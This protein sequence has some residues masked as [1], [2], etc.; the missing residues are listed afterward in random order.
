MSFFRG[1]MKMT[2]LHLAM[3]P[4]QLKGPRNAVKIMVLIGQG[5]GCLTAIGNG[6]RKGN[7]DRTLRGDPDLMPQT[8][9]RVEH[10]PRCSRQAYSGVQG[11]G[12]RRRTAAAQ[13]AGPVC[14]VLHRSD[15][16]SI[17]GND[18]DGPDRLL[19]SSTR[20]AAAQKH[21]L[22]RDKLRL[23]KKFPQ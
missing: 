3:C 22:R 1:Q 21:L 20:P 6:R 23:E 11:G 19:V 5:E 17:Q 7:A 9:D 13:E 8:Q 18:M 10:G 4:G 2:E 16:P 15:G 12:I 14:F